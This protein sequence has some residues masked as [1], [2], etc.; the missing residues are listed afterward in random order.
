[1]IPPVLF[2]LFAGAGGPVAL[3]DPEPRSRSGA[4]P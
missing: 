2:I 4:A 3:P 1:M